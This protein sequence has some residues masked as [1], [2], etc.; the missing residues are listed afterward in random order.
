MAC[1]A[2]GCFGA[3]RC[4]AVG[5]VVARI[6]VA[7][8]FVE[9]RLVA[10]TTRNAIAAPRDVCEA[11]RPR[12]LANRTVDGRLRSTRAVT[13]NGTDVL[14][15]VSNLYTNESDGLRVDSQSRFRRGFRVGNSTRRGSFHPESWLPGPDLCKPIRG[16]WRFERLT[17]PACRA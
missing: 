2:H 12:V 16:A 8:R 11:N 6:D 14:R 13:S 4:R 7:N 5:A 10:V 1:R 15:A 17:E 9:A 3:S